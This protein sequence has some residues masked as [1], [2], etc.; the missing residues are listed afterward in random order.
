M[1]NF[2]LKKFHGIIFLLAVTLAVL[3]RLLYI[4][5]AGGAITIEPD[6]QGYYSAGNFF[7][8][9]FLH[10]YFNT[11]RIPGY[12]MFTSLVISATGHGHPPY[13][14]GKFF[15]GARSIIIVQTIAGVAG[16]IILYDLLLA[17]GI[18]RAARVL[19][20]LFTGLNIYQFIWEHAFLTTALFITFVTIILRLFVS[21]L[22]KPAART[23]GLFIAAS[24][25]AFLLRPA[26]LVIPFILLPFV[27]LR[28]KTKKV[29]ILIATL[30]CVYSAV[31][32]SHIAM[33]RWLYNFKGLS[34]NTDFAVFGRIL[35]FN[36][37][38]DAASSVHPLYDEVVSY[39]AAGGNISI[40]WYFFVAYNNEIYSRMDELKAF[41]RLVLQHQFPEFT[42]TMIGDIPGAFSD[43]DV[44]GVLYRAGRPGIT[45]SFFD[46]LVRIY[47]SIQKMSVIFLILFPCSVW[48]YIKKQSVLHTFLLA[49][50][51]M[52]MYQLVS[53]LVYG[54][55]WDMAGH[56]ITTQTYLFFFCFWWVGRT[57]S[58]IRRHVIQ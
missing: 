31:P 18:S 27:W 24:V 47:A 26:G 19:F 38:V 35:R 14:S 7:T 9:D 34:I 49:V 12:A 57:I 54:G 43:T 48:L 32:G 25:S 51:L 11:N 13:L 39:R 36:I 23:G 55:S 20:T 45:R 53:T 15:N 21:L 2:S 16:L 44:S 8:E 22:K 10:N 58:W 17:I 29:F 37:P 6:S 50:G 1:I 46:T 42:K 33:N 4:T 40:P 28:H 52:E 30:L 3:V 56:M 41:D 5:Y